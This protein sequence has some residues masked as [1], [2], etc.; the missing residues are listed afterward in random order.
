MKEMYR[1]IVPISSHFLFPF[2]TWEEM[3]VVKEIKK[4]H[5]VKLS[6]SGYHAYNVWE[7]FV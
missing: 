7:T 6:Y 1:K 2:L 4:P 3:K 5:L